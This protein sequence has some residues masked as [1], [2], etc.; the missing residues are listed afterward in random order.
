MQS[1]NKLQNNTLLSTLSILS[2]IATVDA[3]SY[4]KWNSTNICPRLVANVDQPT[5][6]TPQRREAHELYFL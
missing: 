1:D 4:V 2:T 5:A 6:A 3:L